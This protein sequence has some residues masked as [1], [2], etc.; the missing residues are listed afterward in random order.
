MNLPR[1]SELPVRIE[2]KNGCL[3][4]AIT[5]KRKLWDR[6]D[7]D[8]KITP[9]WCG[10]VAVYDAKTGERKERYENRD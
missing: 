6:I 9:Q 1:E 4:V 10:D 3:S 5:Y 8:G 2:P 7:K